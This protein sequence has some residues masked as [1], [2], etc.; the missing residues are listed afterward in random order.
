M[1]SL[2]VINVLIG[3][4]KK[5]TYARLEG[6]ETGLEVGVDGGEALVVLD[7]HSDLHAA[8]RLVRAHLIHLQSH[9]SHACTT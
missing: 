8:L 2:R 7:E 6:C 1:V 5:C 4:K 3:S 9:R